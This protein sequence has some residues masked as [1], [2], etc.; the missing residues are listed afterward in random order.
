MQC[1]FSRVK[2]ALIFSI[3]EN[4]MAKIIKIEC[5]EQLLLKYVFYVINRKETRTTQSLETAVF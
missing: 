2:D 1:Y 4:I 3:P 5:S